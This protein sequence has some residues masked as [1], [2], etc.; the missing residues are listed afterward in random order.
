MGRM[1]AR[2]AASPELRGSAPPIPARLKFGCLLAPPNMEAHR[3][4]GRFGFTV[5]QPTLTSYL[6]RPPASAAR[7]FGQSQLHYG[8]GRLAPYLDK[9]ATVK[10]LTALRAV[11]AHAQANEI[12]AAFRTW[13][14][15]FPLLAGSSSP[16]PNRPATPPVG[17]LAAVSASDVAGPASTQVRQAAAGRQTLRLLETLRAVVLHASAD[18]TSGVAMAFDRWCELPPAPM[19]A[20]PHEDRGAA[21]HVPA[22]SSLSRAA[23]RPPAEGDDS[24]H[25]LMGAPASV[26]PAMRGTADD[27]ATAAAPREEGASAAPKPPRLALP[28]RLSLNLLAFGTQDAERAPTARM[29]DSARGDRTPRSERGES[30]PRSHRPAGSETPRMHGADGDSDSEGSP[31]RRSPER[32]H[33]GRGDGVDEHEKRFEQSSSA[34]EQSRGGFE[35]SRGGFGASALGRL[36]QRQQAA[37]TSAPTTAPPVEEM[38]S[39]AQRPA[40][41]APPPAGEPLH[42]SSALESGGGAAFEGQTPECAPGAV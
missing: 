14:Q 28:P 4:S 36:Q 34:F 21:E 12:S 17:A 29:G 39:A 6:D 27:W 11:A 25:H 8:H 19:A 3:A 23:A 40:A 20:W 33:F 16:S 7:P 15:A 37:A 9:S 31:A 26:Q 32:W 13:A 42:T 2:E 30:T 41:A 10:K 5:S 24:G 35:Q 22:S 38:P 1:T 18:Q